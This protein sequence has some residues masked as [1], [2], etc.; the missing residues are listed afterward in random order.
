MNEI[1]YLAVCMAIK[2]ANK[3][4]KKIT[5]LI[6]KIPFLLST[7]QNGD[8]IDQIKFKLSVNLG[9]FYLSFIFA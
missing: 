5:F 9:R 2:A 7:T 6:F 1:E 8:G 3:G 4:S